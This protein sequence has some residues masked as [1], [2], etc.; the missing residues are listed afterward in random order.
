MKKEIFVSII[1]EKLKFDE[2]LIIGAIFKG[3]TI[4]QYKNVEEIENPNSLDDADCIV[5]ATSNSLLVNASFKR[6]DCDKIDVKILRPLLCENNNLSIQLQKRII[7]INIYLAQQLSLRQLSKHLINHSL[8]SSSK[9][10]ENYYSIGEFKGKYFQLFI[11]FSYI[12]N[13]KCS[14]SFNDYL[15][16]FDEQARNNSDLY[17]LNKSL[18]LFASENK[19]LHANI[20]SVIYENIFNKN[21]SSNTRL[22][23]ILN[24]ITGKLNSKSFYVNKLVHS[25]VILLSIFDLDLEYLLHFEKLLNSTS[26]LNRN[27]N[28]YFAITISI[29]FDNKRLFSH[30]I[31][32]PQEPVTKTEIHYETLLKKTQ[33]LVDYATSKNLNNDLFKRNVFNVLINSYKLNK[34]DTTNTSLLSNYFKLEDYQDQD[35]DGLFSELN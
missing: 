27:L 12:L 33:H 5:F 17:E 26:D 4:K 15:K 8:N 9:H 32:I 30:F 7:L 16:F 28:I 24:L 6:F 31:K 14:E 13:Y 34:I 35:L 11:L 22:L 18:I 29:L 19:T 10:I 20:S 3:N 2:E 1:S 23:W 21:N 25:Y